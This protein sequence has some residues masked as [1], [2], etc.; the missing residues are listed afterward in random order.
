M[1]ANATVSDRYVRAA[2]RALTGA[3]IAADTEEQ[4]A[5]IKAGYA[6]G[7]L[8]EWADW[9]LDDEAKAAADEALSRRMAERR[10]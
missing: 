9:N 4:L 5:S 2:V 6:L 7:L 8:V 10:S 1:S 3:I